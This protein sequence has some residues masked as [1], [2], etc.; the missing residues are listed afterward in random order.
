[1]VAT[2][3]GE[4]AF[5][6]YFVGQRCAPVV[7]G[8]RFEG[9]DAA[10][11]SPGAL[12]AL[13]DD[14]LTG[15]ILC[16]SN[17]FVSIGPMLALPD[18]RAALAGVSAPVLAVS[19]I[20]GGT[21]IKGPAAKMMTELGLDV[22]SLAV[23]RH[24]GDLIDAIL[25]DDQDRAELS[26]REAGDPEMLVAPTVMTDNASRIALAQVCLDLLDGLRR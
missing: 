2:P 14:R 19:P 16:P 15:V 5:Q 7:Q 22:S 13:A 4:L 8:F 12:A 10:K 9:T 17:P 6:D 21:A 11:A 26:R 23:A 24:Y 20:V 3:D 1:M 25:I 18:F